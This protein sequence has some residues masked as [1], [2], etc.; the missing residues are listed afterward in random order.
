MVRS[1][2]D[3]VEIVAAERTRLSLALEES[4]GLMR[5]VLAEKEEAEAKAAAAAAALYDAEAAKRRLEA[6]VQGYRDSA[7]SRVED[8]E[9]RV[10]LLALKNVGEMEAEFDRVKREA[11]EG[12]DTLK[13]AHSQA[14]EELI[15]ANDSLVLERNRSG[16]MQRKIEALEAEIKELKREAK[17]KPVLRYHSNF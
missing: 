16:E 2:E 10:Q 8:M 17:P 12:L 13:A 9:R 6:K 5:S 3:E 4:A 1:L 15:L 11:K 7:A 14:L